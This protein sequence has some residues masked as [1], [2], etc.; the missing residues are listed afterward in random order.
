MTAFPLWYLEMLHTNFPRQ[1]LLYVL[2]LMQEMYVPIFLPWINWRIGIGTEAMLLLLYHA[3]M[4]LG[5]RKVT[6]TV[7]VFN[8]P[9][10]GHSIKSGYKLI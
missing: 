9:S 8:A 4:I 7:K 6:A 3:F 10:M 1:N 2:G 5:L